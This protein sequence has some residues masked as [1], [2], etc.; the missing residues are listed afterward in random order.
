MKADNKFPID[1][2]QVL[3]FA[4]SISDDNPLYFD[5]DF[6]KSQGYKGI[7]APLTFIEAYH[8]FD[9][10]YHLRPNPNKQ[11]PGSPRK[12]VKKSKL[13]KNEK[14]IKK[15]KKG[16]GLHAEQHFEYH[17][18]VYSGDK[19]YWIDHE[20]RTWERE[21]KK[22]G[23]LIFTESITE[24]FNQNDILVVTAKKVTVITEKVVKTQDDDEKKNL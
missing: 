18:P 19:L 9:T 16:T 21:G 8:Q 13:N 10:R 2:S 6:A 24:F 12:Q 20:P 4:R 23:T 17:E 15:R 1:A 11:W 5:D 22:G 3:F 7:I 14:D